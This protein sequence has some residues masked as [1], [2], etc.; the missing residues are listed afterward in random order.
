MSTPLKAPVPAALARLASGFLGLLVLSVAL[1]SVMAGCSVDGY[2]NGRVQA[3]VGTMRMAIEQY[4]TEHRGRYPTPG[5]LVAELTRGE[6]GYVSG[7]RKPPT[8]RTE[9]PQIEPITPG[10]AGLPSAHQVAAAG[11]HPEVGQVVGKGEVGE[12]PTTP[13]QFGAI[14]YDLDAK[15]GTYVLYGIGQR[16]KRAEGVAV[17]SNL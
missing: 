13:W 17:A 1:P 7:D 10:A 3:T 16:N 5:R 11:K 8:P 15:T 9:Q 12:A 14:L 4:G 2:R 6:R